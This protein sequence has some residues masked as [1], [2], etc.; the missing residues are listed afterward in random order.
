MKIFNFCAA[1]FF[2]GYT[3]GVKLLNFRN[4]LKAVFITIV[5]KIQMIY[6]FREVFKLQT[7]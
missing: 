2:W 6:V 3:R 4:A 7:R 5:S 1:L